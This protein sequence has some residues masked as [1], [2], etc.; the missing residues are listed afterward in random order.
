MGFKIKT[1]N[2]GNI[3]GFD[4]NFSTDSIKLE[5]KNNKSHILTRYKRFTHNNKVQKMLK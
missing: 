4:A 3:A 5:K 2:N 1:L